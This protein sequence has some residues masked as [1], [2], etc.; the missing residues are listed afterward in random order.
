M[1]YL[2]GLQLSG[3]Q[4]LLSSLGIVPLPQ[5]VQVPSLL[6]LSFKPEHTGSLHRVLSGGAG[7][8]K[9]LHLSHLPSIVVIKL[10]LQESEVHEVRAGSS[11]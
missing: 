3:T 6:I 1:I 2:L 10:K 8:K 5:G 4:D 11:G 7:V 9:S